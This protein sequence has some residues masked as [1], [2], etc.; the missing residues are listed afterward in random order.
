MTDVDGLAAR[1]PPTFGWGAATAAYQIE[2]GWDADGKGPSIWD[3]FCRV[4]DAIANGDTGD[5]ACE[6]YRRFRDDVA[7]MASLGLTAYRFS[8]SW[9]R[10]VPTGTGRVNEPGLAFYDA[11]VEALLEHD[12]RPL[13]TLYHWDLPQAL[14]DRGGWEAADVAAS[15]AD[16]AA[17]VA[18]RLGDRVADWVTVNE[19]AVVAFV[20]HAEGRH[21]P[22]VRDFG[23]ALRVAHHL[24][25]AH[26]AAASAVRA[27]TTRSRVGIALNLHPCSPASDSPDDIAASA[28]LD[29]YQNRWFLDPLFG[30]GYPA[31]MVEAYAA[32]LPDSLAEEVAGFDGALDFLGVNY[33]TPKIARAGGTGPLGVE[34]VTAPG[35][36]VTATGWE[37]YPDGL[38][39]ILLRVHRDYGPADRRDGE[40]RGVRRRAGRRRVRR[41]PRPKG[42]PRLPF[43]GG[44]AGARSRRAARGLLRLVAHGQLRV[45][46]GLQQA[47]RPRLRRLRD[48]GPNREGEWPLVPRSRRGIAPARLGSHE[49]LL[50]DG[51]LLDPLH[52]R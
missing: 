29:G 46:G 51:A 48:A 24:L 3:T 11:L 10:V 52:E 17:L 30:L 28:R 33:Y 35:A 8:I 21:A 31:D 39:E 15:F 47:V 16:Y 25:L 14:Q 45:G 4:P 42:V 19:P 36:P 43:R 32:L 44:C 20:G 12:I 23:V 27:N 9:P 18:G 1:F 7:L 41:R 38:R 37:V 5:T 26:G 49:D 40:R 6:H 13:V 2:G 50:D 22:G 34:T